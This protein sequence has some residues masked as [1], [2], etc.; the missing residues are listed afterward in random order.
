MGNAQ[1]GREPAV[2]LNLRPDG[3]IIMTTR[4]EI[5]NIVKNNP[6]ISIKEI[7]DM[8][9]CNENGVR[10]KIKGYMKFDMIRLGERKLVTTHMQSGREK[11]SRKDWVNTYYV[12]EES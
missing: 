7:H 6:G 12:V 4:E 2:I 8:V 1:K 3:E 5:Y 10:S 11:H 9:E